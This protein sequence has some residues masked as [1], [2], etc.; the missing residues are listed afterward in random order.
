MP[1]DVDEELAAF[2]NRERRQTIDRQD[3]DRMDRR[4]RA[5]HS[6]AEFSQQEMAIIHGPVPPWS[7]E[8]RDEESNYQDYVC[9]ILS[10]VPQEANMRI[11]L[12][13]V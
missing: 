4:L 1:I 13:H 5:S 10:E 7:Q 3:R 9:P 6:Q 8:D 11:W 2:S 12:G